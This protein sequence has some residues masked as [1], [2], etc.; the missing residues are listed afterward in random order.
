MNFAKLL[1]FLRIIFYPTMKSYYLLLL[2]FGSSL[3]FAQKGVIKGRVFNEINN[4]SLPFANV[5]IPSISVGTTTDVD[6]NF[7]LSDL[8]P[9][10]Y[11]IEVSFIGFKT[12]IIPEV[13]ITNVTQVVLEIG[14]T[15]DS[16]VLQAVDVVANPFENKEES[17]LSVQSLGVNEIR[18]SAGGNQD[19]SIVVQSLPGVASTVSFRN[20]L[21]IR[22]GG[23]NENRFY[24]DGIEIPNINH[25]AT[26]GSSGGP[27]GIINVNFLEG[28]DLY[29][30]AFP[31]ERGNTLSSVMELRLKE[32]RDDRMGYR[33]QLG[34]SDIGL[35]IDGPLGART[36][37]IASV[38][39]SYLQFLF[40]LLE[41]PFLPTYN[42][43]Q[44]KIKHKI[45]DKNEITFLGIGAYDISTLNTEANETEN[46]QYLLANLP[47]YN[48]WNYTL[49][50]KYTNY[51]QNS[52][53]SVFLSRSHLFNN[54]E[55]YR[56]NL[57]TPE[58]LILNYESQ[59]IENKLRVENTIRTNGYKIVFGGGLEQVTYTNSTYNLVAV[60]DSVE[61]I[62]YNTRLDLWKYSAFGSVS[63][64]FGRL[65]TSLGL[66]MDGFSYSENTSNPLDQLSPR[67]SLSYGLNNNWSLNFNTGI[68][69]QL[70][71]YTVLGYKDETGA[72]INQENGITYMRN[73]HVVAGV[74]YLYKE[75]GKFTLEGFYKHY[76]NYPLLLRDSISLANL[77][78]D[79]GVV[80]NEPAAPLSDGRAYGAEFLY[81]QKLFKGF[82]GILAYT[83]VRS[84]FTSGDEYIVSSWDNRHLISLTGGKRWG[85]NWELGLRWR[86]LGGAPFTPYDLERSFTREVWDVTFRG[87][88]DYSRL[89]SERIGVYHQLDARID[90]KW[91]FENLNINFY[92]DVQNLYG[93]QLQG[94]PFVDVQKDDFGQPIV[95]PNDPD[96]YLYKFIEN[97]I[98]TVLPTL[99]VIIDF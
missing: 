19:I 36:S 10:V 97:T 11:N 77:G 2:L 27:V 17:P 29:T 76:S 18:R 42:D 23:P 51:R 49:G 92:F 31:A 4:E 20:D 44:F 90:K 25:F 66:R 98:G 8:K 95:D 87:L 15:E 39:R 80:G 71:P 3:L 41:L 73:A 48:Q 54:A 38:R 85:N 37:L 35:T 79:F 89:N 82:Y 7:V 33:A 58:N 28:V 43:A 6:G 32:G 9:G 81:Q 55:K 50:A 57:R 62:N 60:G 22:G 1:L 70:P 65:Q 78:G 56:N 75:R 30:G 52:F 34:A 84:E 12:R 86:L 63:K 53:T 69:Y 99:G 5:T 94:Q 26:Q 59:E 64:A 91:F 47:E 83:F 96:M 45:D 46:Q 88:P 68:Y 74:Q 13:A 67:L 24:L 72:L 21:I 61:T 14:L 93:F 16:E 40:S